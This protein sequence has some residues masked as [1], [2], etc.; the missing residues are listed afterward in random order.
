MKAFMQGENKKVVQPDGQIIWPTGASGADEALFRRTYTFEE[1][2]E[3]VRAHLES[4]LTAQQAMDKFGVRSKS[5]FFRWCTAYREGGP[6]AL[7]PRRR[8]RPPKRRD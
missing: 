5:A 7:R 4:G 6:E 1:K 3:A 2:L 8:G